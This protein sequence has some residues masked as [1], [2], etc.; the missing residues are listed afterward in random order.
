M[1]EKVFIADLAILSQSLV[2]VNLPYN[3]EVIIDFQDPNKFDFSFKYM[4]YFHKTK[5][6]EV[7]LILEFIM[8]DKSVDPKS[9]VIKILV[10]GHYSLYGSSK[11]EDEKELMYNAGLRNIVSFLRTSIFNITSM[12]KSGGITL[13][14]IDIESLKKNNRLKEE[15][16]KKT[17]VSKK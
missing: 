15:D 2:A 12:T 8:T 3:K 4:A 11:K 1:S 5:K 16:T 6:N 7:R 14:P 10:E 17:K 13:P 9:A